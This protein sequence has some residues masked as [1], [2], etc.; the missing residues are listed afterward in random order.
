MD[1]AKEIISNRIR[2]QLK[3]MDISAITLLA[4]YIGATEV[5]FRAYD[6]EHDVNKFLDY[7]RDSKGGICDA[8][9]EIVLLCREINKKIL[10]DLYET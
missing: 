8:A 6:N 1:E 3:T 5:L 2:A 9:C 7:C 10:K 4:A